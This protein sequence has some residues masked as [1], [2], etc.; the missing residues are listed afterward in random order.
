MRKKWWI[1]LVILIIAIALIGFLASR[2]RVI[3][4]QK[5][6][7]QQ[8]VVKKTVSASGIVKSFS[9]ANLAF[10]ATGKLTDINVKKGD[11]VAKN[12][13]LAAIYNIPI[14]ASAQSAK[15][16]RD[17]ALR[18]LD[19]HLENK[20]ELE[21]SMGSDSYAIETRRLNELVSKAEADYQAALG[22]VSNSYIYA[23][24][25]GVVIDTPY[26]IGEVAAAGAT[27]IKLADLDN[28]LFEIELD[29]EDFGLLKTGQKVD[30][31]LD[32]FEN[33]TFVGEVQD[34]PYFADG[35]SG[36]AF[37]VKISITDP[38]KDKILLGMTGDAYIVLESTDKEVDA[39]TYDEV[40]YDIDDKP[41]V[42]VDNNGVAAKEYLT[43]GID[44]D[45]YTE[46]K[47]PVSKTIIKSTNKDI[48]L[49][50]GQ[51]VKIAE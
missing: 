37:T 20:S 29:Q 9:E 43:I 40:L 32:S 33:K 26:E 16:L 12:Q 31:T 11:K 30:I 13:Y 34:I 21:D 14:Q 7:V 50:E 25:D 36:K 48:P 47:N 4:V 27:A 6:E 49:E 15:D 22:T 39:L 1:F 44:G 28:L 19:M 3:S 51:K 8:K 17:V 5:V 18:N 2:N 35:T 38:E 42:L 10:S 24:F 41:Y 23:P 46:L 45:I